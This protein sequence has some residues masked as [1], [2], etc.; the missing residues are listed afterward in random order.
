M[1]VPPA[2]FPGALDALANP[3]ATTN[4]DDDGF[5]LDLVIGRIQDIL[6][7][8]EAKVGITA[9]LPAAG[10]GV[11]RQTGSGTSLWGKIQSGDIAPDQILSSHIAPGTIQGSDLGTGVAR[12][13]TLTVAA[14]NASPLM[15]SMA[16]YVCDG[17]S[18]Q[19][20]INAALSALPA[21]GGTVQLSEG[22]FIIDGVVNTQKAN[23][24]LA[25]Q[26]IGS[27]FIRVKDTAGAGV[28]ASL[29]ALN[30]VTCGV[31]DLTVDGNKA[32][33]GPQ[34]AMIGVSA[35]ASNTTLYRVQVVNSVGHGAVVGASTTQGVLVRD[36]IFQSNTVTGC[37]VRSLTTG[38]LW[39]TTLIG[40][41]SY[42]NATGFSS[43]AGPVVYDSCLAFN[44]TGYGFI[45]AASNTRYVGCSSRANTNS[46][47][48][49]NG[50]D[51]SQVVGCYVSHNNSSGIQVS[52]GSC[53]LVVG[54]Y[55][56]S[57]AAYGILVQGAGSSA[58]RDNYIGYNGTSA[59]SYH[60]IFVQSD[61]CYI[62]GNSVRRSAA[63]PDYGIAIAGGSL[64][65]LG[66]NDS[67]NGGV[68]GE[69]YDSGTQT[70]YDAK[71]RNTVTSAATLLNGTSVAQGVWTDVCYDV[72]FTVSSPT[73]VITVSTTGHAQAGGAGSVLH[74][75]F[76]SRLLIDGTVASPIIGGAILPIAGGTVAVPFNGVWHITGL[77]MAGHNVRMQMASLS[78]GAQFWMRPGP[79][80]ITIQVKEDMT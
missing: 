8:L 23:S 34:T 80:S 4:R 55:V 16:D 58:V 18:D 57:N 7:A 68:L 65:H 25:G 26:G 28:N 31:R 38:A 59:A 67:V 76:Q 69:V 3:T 50:G 1:P 46:G 2:A 5:E 43:D 64:N 42:G 19:V 77:T 15:K 9:S 61:Y 41:A 60:Q 33:N 24:T 48:V 66:G 27:T 74:S 17:T 29:I 79:E 35:Q 71:I 14:S 37:I 47:I 44:N 39:P 70:C 32:N 75:V 54:N 6:E 45:T 49:L 63:S 30:H 10:G 13:V 40:C 22:T 12:A 53:H 78:S 11:L 36:C 72:P 62:G 73:S 56:L 20:E 52:T 51:Y 21:V